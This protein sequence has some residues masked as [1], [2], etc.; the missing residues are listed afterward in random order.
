[1]SMLGLALRTLRYRTGG[2]AASF[3]ATLLGAT[4]LM[5]FTS[6][7]DTALGDNVDSDTM[8][9]LI[10][11]SSVAGG[12]CLII[13][14]FAV[15]STLTLSV[16]Q[17][18]GE[19]ALLKSVGATPGQI[20]RMIVTESGLIA[21]VAAMLAVA[22]SIGL[23]RLL[24]QLLANTGQI[25]PG[26]SYRFGFFAVTAGLGVTLLAAM[27]AALFA[28]RRVTRMRA[29]EAITA[30]AS[31]RP[32]LGLLRISAALFLIASGLTCGMLTILLYRDAGADAMQ[33]AGQA[34]I[35]T[36]AGF[37]LLS[38]VLL[39]MVTG[40]LARPLERAGG[41]GGYLAV[42]NLRRRS[43]QLGG[44]LMPVILFTGISMGTI[45]MQSI[46][47]R[48]SDGTFPTWLERN[49]EMLNFMIVG[50]IA[51]FSAI[52][53]VNTLVAAG[54][55]RRE[56]F[57]RQRLAGAVPGQV[58]GTVAA[59]T[60]VITLTGVVAGVISALTTAIPYSIV[61]TGA[62]LPD[63]PVIIWPAIAITAVSLTF[64]TTMATARFALR[65]PATAF[66]T[67]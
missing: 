57:N 54:V 38:P 49:I 41:A 46:E 21:A 51:L 61:R 58:L 6:M 16:R 3:I 60:V 23:G 24:W 48:A 63:A 67:S 34:S 8:A 2:F 13:V 32:G 20:N 31:E 36:A 65:I 64:A 44:A 55:Y 39:R 11:V 59:E 40:F 33:T 1:M 17:R 22:P 30:A 19:M 18:E 10:I 26:V 28:A 9:S 35:W 25:S 45:V 42:R 4:I 12:W 5:T 27:A 53:L 56:E 47:N 62:L 50:M 7:L 52:M 14:F 66:L 15:V 29:R 37:A 43:H